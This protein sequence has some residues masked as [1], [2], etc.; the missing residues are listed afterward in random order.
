MRNLLFFVLLLTS[1]LIV[2]GQSYEE[3]VLRSYHYADSSEYAAAAECLKAAM[4]LEP[5]NK[6]N[7]ALLSNLGTMQRRQRKFDEALISY[8]AA[9][10]Q[11]PDD[12]V[13]LL[14]RAEL[15]TDMDET[16]KAIG[17]YNSLLS[18]DPKNEKALYGRGLLYT[19]KG[20]FIAA[21]ADF[22]H[23]LETYKDSFLGRLGYAIL[24]KARGK[25]DESE[26]IFSYLADKY[27][28]NLRVNEE[29]AELYF[30]TKRNGRAMTELNKVFVAVKEPSAEMYMLR[31]RIKLAQY[32]KEAA[33][34][35]FRRAGEL[36][37]NKETVDKLIKECF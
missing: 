9:L 2:S 10:G 23:I 35:D 11:R 36:G 21:Q 33:A 37:Y 26:T 25:Y 7:Y 5:A 27:P 13:I 8:T 16:D 20:E 6:F 28:D 30:L 3:L 18:S 4:R 22:E 15:F 17:D 19:G 1:T 12:E 34:I 29:R 31:G 14:N 24:E 32:E